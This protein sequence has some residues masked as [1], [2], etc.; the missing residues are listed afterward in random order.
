MST[1]R[2]HASI[3]AEMMMTQGDPWVRPGPRGEYC[4]DCA[5][6]E[7]C[8]LERPRPYET[9]TRWRQRSE[10]NDRAEG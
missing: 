1:D 2:G 9:C 10:P 5:D 7:T 6:R 3:E 8:L 4:V